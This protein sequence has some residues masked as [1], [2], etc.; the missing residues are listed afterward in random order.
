[1][2]LSIAR[3]ARCEYDIRRLFEELTEMQ[4]SR[5]DI[6][7]Y[8]LDRMQKALLQYVKGKIIIGDSNF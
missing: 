7:S 5:Q 2:S 8:D 1:M 3:Q 6:P 4:F